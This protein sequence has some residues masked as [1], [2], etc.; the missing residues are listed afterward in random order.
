MPGKLPLLK[1]P[2]HSRHWT[3]LKNLA[4]KSGDIS[5]SDNLKSKKWVKANQLKKNGLF[6]DISRH[7]ATDDIW[8]ALF[9]LARDQGLETW[10]DEMFSGE[11]VN[12]S[13]NRPALHTALRAPENSSIEVEGHNVIP[14]IQEVLDRL[15]KFVSR[16]HQEGRIT[17]I[18]NIGIGGSYLGPEMVYNALSAHHKKTKRVHFLAN[19]DGHACH[20]LLEKLNPE[21]TMFLVASKT[22]TTQETLTNAYTARSWIISKLGDKAV[23]DHFAALSTNDNAARDFGIKAETIFPF[24][25]WVGGRFSL[26]SAIG[27]PIALGTDFDKFRELLAG[28]RA[29]DDHFQNTE[30]EN[31]IPVRLGLLGLWYRNFLGASSYACLPYDSRLERFPAYLQQLDMESNGKSIDRNNQ[32]VA[33]KTGPVVFGEPGTNGQHAFYQLIHQG[34]ELIPC[35][36]IAVRRPDHPYESHHRILLSHVLAQANALAFGRNLGQ[37]GGNIQK[38]FDG[39]RPSSL[40]IL[41]KL[42]PYN[43]GQL[44]ALYEHKIFVQGVIWNINSFDQW[45]VELG[46]DI[47]STILEAFSGKNDQDFDISTAVLLEYLDK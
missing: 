1:S 2:E 21:T 19:I 30:L 45:G 11:K 32:R 5:L 39:N 18:V 15:E 37:T 8:Q 14:D 31:N 38:A 28:A 24:W 9:G 3:T 7:I 26:W 23:P 16:I 35:E 46:K 47:A 25:D 42:T 13:E 6:A 34:T 44:I 29:M 4:A 36:F 41:D 12:I 40:I 27:L 33:Y 22:F 17:D 43:L 20:Q 10:R